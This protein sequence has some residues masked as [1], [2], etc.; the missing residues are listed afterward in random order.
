MSCLD[1]AVAA[2][3]RAWAAGEVCAPDAAVEFDVLARDRFNQQTS[4]IHAFGTYAR[5]RGFA[6]ATHQPAGALPMVPVSAYKRA[7]LYTAQAAATPVARFETSGTTDGQPGVVQLADAALYDLSLRAA[8]HHFVV[9][10]AP[11]RLEAA[12]NAG[13][14]RVISLVPNRS[15]RPHSS[16]GHMVDVIGH[17]WAEGPVHHVMGAAPDG[18]IRDTL[19]VI[20]LREALQVAVDSQ[21]PV[22]LLTTSIA[23]HLLH[24]AWPTDVRLT[25]PAGSRLMDTGGPKGRRITLSR[26]AQHAWLHQT[27]GIPKA[28]IVGELGMTELGSQ[29]YETNARA[30]LIGD[31]PAVR[32]YVAPPWLRTV[33]LDPTDLRALPQGEQG[34]LGHV[35]LANADTCAFVLTGDLGHLSALP[36]PYGEALH[37]HGRAP[38]HDWRGCGLD[39]ELLFG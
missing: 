38:G 36:K 3:M 28:L 9:P 5:A 2:W 13:P 10:D 11:L 15:L 26:P 12:P 39:V 25:L 14:F 20:A 35:D 33:A 19:D 23:L 31:A 8:F 18:T 27:F 4:E 1:T 29:R 30:H 34:L 6:T 32:A 22:L 7:V 24:E 21:T 16:L 17:T 37:L